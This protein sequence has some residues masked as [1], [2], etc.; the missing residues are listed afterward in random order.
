MELGKILSVRDVCIGVSWE[1]EHLHVLR[2]HPYVFLGEK[3]N[4]AIKNIGVLYM[5][6]KMT[7]LP[8]KGVI[9]KK[10]RGKCP[11]EGH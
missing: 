9:M 2:T 8:L 1:R 6:S 10:N 7:I 4:L 3:W 11:N 5:I